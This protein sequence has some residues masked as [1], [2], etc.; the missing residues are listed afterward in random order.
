MRNRDNHEEYDEYYNETSNTA[1]GI[2]TPRDHESF[3]PLD[4]LSDAVEE[5]VD[6]VQHSFG[7]HDPDEHV[8]R[9][10]ADRHSF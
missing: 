1:A 9:N 8:Y 5:M 7:S 2:N 6:N 3:G 10:Y 4:M